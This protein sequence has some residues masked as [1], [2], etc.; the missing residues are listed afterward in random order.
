MLSKLA[1]GSND[2]GP[3]N[4][5]ARINVFVRVALGAVAPIIESWRTFAIPLAFGNRFV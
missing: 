5:S 4:A 2:M 1:V 3:I